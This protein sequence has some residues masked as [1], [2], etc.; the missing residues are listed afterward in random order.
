MNFPRHRY[1]ED[2]FDFYSFWNRN[3]TICYRVT[4]RVT[5]VRERKRKYSSCSKLSFCS[6]TLGNCATERK[7]VILLILLAVIAIL[8]CT[9]CQVADDGLHQARLQLCKV[10][11][12]NT[13]LRHASMGED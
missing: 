12:V 10:S 7:A 3:K 6:L 9:L 13:G 2:C 11:R 1:S 8:K 5:F 4:H